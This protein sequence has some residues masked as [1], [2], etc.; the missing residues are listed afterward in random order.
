MVQKA[1][2]GICA[3]PFK[4]GEYTVLCFTDRIGSDGS[5]LSLGTARELQGS[6]QQ[7]TVK[8][9]KCNNVTRVKS[10]LVKEGVETFPPI[11]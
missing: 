10:E 3:V 1:V 8:L 7:A 11:Q 9:I 4:K 6:G 2:G 5:H